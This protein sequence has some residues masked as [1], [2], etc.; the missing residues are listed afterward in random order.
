MGRNLVESTEAQWP[1]NVDGDDRALVEGRQELS[2]ASDIV[3]QLAELL[4]RRGR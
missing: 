2:D 1:W 3:A 4:E